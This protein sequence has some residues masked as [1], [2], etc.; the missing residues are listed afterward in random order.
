MRLH[1]YA[2]K[3]L[4]Y[5]DSDKVKGWVYAC[6]LTNGAMGYAQIYKT[7]AVRWFVELGEVKV[8]LCV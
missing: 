2:Q 7:C 8:V 4:K 3:R 6:I 1:V 5:I